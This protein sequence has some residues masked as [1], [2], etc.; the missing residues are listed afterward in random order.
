MFML[1]LL[2]GGRSMLLPQ[3]RFFLSVGP[4][5]HPAGSAV[6]ADVIHNRRVIDYGAVDV[7]VVN[8]GRVDVRHRGVIRE[9]AVVPIAANISHA[10]VAESVVNPAI[11][12]DVR[13]PVAAVPEI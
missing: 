1:S 6:V 4:R 12:T 10:D 9:D 2:G 11:E 8:D 5:V 7:G 3:C 13:A